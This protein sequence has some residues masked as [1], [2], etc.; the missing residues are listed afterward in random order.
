MERTLVL[1]KPDA[2]QRGLLGEII[3][4]FERKGL[5]LVGMKMMKLEDALLDEHYSHLNHLPFFGEIKKFMMLGP[6][7][8]TC[9]VG[10]DCIETVRRLCGVTNAREAAPGTIR[11]DFGMSIQAN[12]VHASDSVETA[13]NEVPRFFS[14]N[15]LFHYEWIQKPY[16]YTKQE[17]GE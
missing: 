5:K 17:S 12:L 6:V 13:A 2:V 14:K 9:W 8:A 4:R 3:T 15:E 16:L 10:V 1:L 7:I 11:G